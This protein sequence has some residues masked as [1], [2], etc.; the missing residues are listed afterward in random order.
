MKHEEQRFFKFCCKNI[1]HL[2]CNT[3]ELIRLDKDFRDGKKSAIEELN[4]HI[5]DFRLKFRN[6]MRFKELVELY[7]EIYNVSKHLLIYYVKKWR[8]KG[9]VC[10]LNYDD[11]MTDKDEELLLYGYFNFISVGCYLNKKKI[12]NFRYSNEYNNLL[13]YINMI[14]SRIRS[15]NTILWKHTKSIE[16][17][18]INFQ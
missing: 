15:H 1:E 5:S 7:S 3:D 4:D 12:W 13:K 9:F 14:P 8:D 16:N 18:F 10:Y 17:Q 6:N 2:K 11:Q